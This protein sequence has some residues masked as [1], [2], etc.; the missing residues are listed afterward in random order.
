[1]APIDKQ[2]NVVSMI[3]TFGEMLRDMPDG[4][5]KQEF[6]AFLH[7]LTFGNKSLTDMLDW[8]ENKI[9]QASTVQ[10]QDLQTNAKATKKFWEDIQDI[11][12]QTYKENKDVA[13]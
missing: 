13:S 9:A 6:S 11:I 12:I 3:K 2:K 1:M 4:D 10:H 8:T 7:Q 5:L